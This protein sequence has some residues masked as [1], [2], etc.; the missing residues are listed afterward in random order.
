[1]LKEAIKSLVRSNK[2]GR[3]LE[4]STRTALNRRKQAKRVRE[5]SEERPS[6]SRSRLVEDLARMGIAAG[7]VVYLFSS[8]KSIGF[9]D[10]GPQT[11]FDALYEVLTP[12]GTLMV[13][14]FSMPGG[15]MYDAC[16]TEGYIYDPRTA[17][18]GLGDIPAMFLKQPNLHRS[19]HPT[20]NVSAVGK[21]AQ[22]L[23]EGHH[24][25]SST[26]GVDSPFDRLV[27][28]EGKI[29]GIGVS[30][31]PIT[32][33]HMVEDTLGDEFP[34]PVRMDAT[35]PIPCRTHDGDLVTV[36][37]TPL[38][39][40]YSAGRIDHKGAGHLREFLWK[41]YERAG[42]LASGSVGEATTW[43]VPAKGC[44]EHL[45]TLARQGVT[46]YSTPDQLE[47]YENP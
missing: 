43:I 5:L 32:L 40:K 41:E 28:L 6:I 9:V 20:H 35:Y 30:V 37:V 29:L 34:L 3:K 24:L 12:E 47:R 42:L 45:V 4:E 7:D 33:Y 2:L 21:Q 10:G 15:T 8:L 38:D 11:L 1:M 39:P 25:A 14:T 27:K 23:T 17:E 19:I 22:Y 26:Y 44:F 13:P 16:L 46:I 36:D 18:T 31:A